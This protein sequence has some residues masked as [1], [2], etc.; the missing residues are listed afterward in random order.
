[1]HWEIY[2]VHPQP[3]CMLFVDTVCKVSTGCL[4]VCSGKKSADKHMQIDRQTDWDKITK[5]NGCLH[6]TSQ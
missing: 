5:N 4:A 6:S 1:M 3:S 2:Y